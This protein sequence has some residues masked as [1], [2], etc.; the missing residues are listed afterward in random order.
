MPG[1]RTFVIILGNVP[2]IIVFIHLW[3]TLGYSMIISGQG[4]CAVLSEGDGLW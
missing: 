3:K 4:Q 2:A 1:V